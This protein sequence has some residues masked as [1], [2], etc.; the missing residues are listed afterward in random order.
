[1]LIKIQTIQKLN[2]IIA[3]LSPAAT[4]LHYPTRGDH[5]EQ[6]SGFFQNTFSA[7]IYTH[8]C[9]CFLIYFYIPYVNC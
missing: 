2:V 5:N 4:Q 1:M 7:Y 9:I 3:N 8:I 6:F